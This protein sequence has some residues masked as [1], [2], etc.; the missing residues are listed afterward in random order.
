MALL[1]LVL[2]VIPD[3]LV[4]DILGFAAIRI[5]T[6]RYNVIPIR[7]LVVTLLGVYSE[8]VLTKLLR[9]IQHRPL[10]P[11]ALDRDCLFPSTLRS[12]VL[13]DLPRVAVCVTY[14][15]VAPKRVE[16]LDAVSLCP[17]RATSFLARQVSRC[18]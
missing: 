10:I 11:L 2:F 9:A 7:H 4:V 12:V 17:H 14:V 5:A 13:D 15:V 8:P 3:V 18:S 16:F 1:I 6:K